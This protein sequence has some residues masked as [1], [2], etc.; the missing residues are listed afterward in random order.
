MSQRTYH[1]KSHSP[2]NCMFCRRIFV[3]SPEKNHERVFKFVYMN[4]PL[5]KSLSG[6]ISLGNLTELF[7]NK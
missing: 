4:P 3:I 6:H 5:F 2:L 1:K 7:K